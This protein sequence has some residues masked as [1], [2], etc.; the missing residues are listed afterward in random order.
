MKVFLLILCSATTLFGLSFRAIQ[1]RPHI[2][3]YAGDKAHRVPAD[4]KFIGLSLNKN[5]VKHLIQ[6]SFCDIGSNL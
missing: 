4:E 5:N 2:Y 1:E 6:K 3:L